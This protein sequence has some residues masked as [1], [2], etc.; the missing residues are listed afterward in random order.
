MEDYTTYSSHFCSPD[1]RKM[2]LTAPSQGNKSSPMCDYFRFCRLKFHL[3][4]GFKLHTYWRTWGWSPYRLGTAY[5]LC[6]AEKSCCRF[7]AGL[8]SVSWGSFAQRPI[9][10]LHV[11]TRLCSSNRPAL[12]EMGFQFYGM[13]KCTKWLISRSEEKS[14]GV[15]LCIVHFMVAKFMTMDRGKADKK[16]QVTRTKR[17]YMC[18]RT[19]NISKRK[20]RDKRVDD[21]SQRHVDVKWEYVK[22]N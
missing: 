7:I 14:F 11:W 3:Q 15:R 2:P 1:W 9:A 12:R 5:R 18:I 4:S 13:N 10:Q 20:K 17:C 21:I 8:S 16:T 19:Q 22:R 6:I